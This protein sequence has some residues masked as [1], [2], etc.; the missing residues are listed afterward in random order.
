MKDTVTRIELIY[1]FN[2]VANIW[3]VIVGSSQTPVD[4]AHKD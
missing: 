3:N 4:C 1:Q 2:Y